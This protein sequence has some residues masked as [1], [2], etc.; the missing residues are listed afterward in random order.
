MTDRMTSGRGL[1]RRCLEVVA[2]S[3]SMSNWFDE[4]S[5][6]TNDIWSSGSLAMSVRTISRGLATYGSM[7]VASGANAAGVGDGRHALQWRGL[8]AGRRGH[9]RTRRAAIVSAS[10]RSVS[11]LM[12]HRS[13]GTPMCFLDRRV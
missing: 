4:T 6:R 5:S 10:I 8:L 12:R 11:S 7:R 3:A 1:A 13:L 9:H 2:T